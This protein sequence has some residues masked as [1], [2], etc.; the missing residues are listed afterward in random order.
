MAGAVACVLFTDLVGSTELMARVGDAAFDLLRNEHFGHLRQV[1]AR[2][3][4]SEIKNTGDGVLAAFPSAAEALGAAVAAQQ[5]TEAHA[6]RAE[7]NL[8]LRV[9]LALG[10]VAMEAGDVFGTPVVEA[11]RLVAAARPGQILC[12]ALTRAVAG[13]RAAVA[14]SEVGALELKGLPEPVPACE[15]M[16]EAAPA[17]ADV[18][19]PAL[20]AGTGRIFVG[21]DGDLA[22]LRQLWKESA[23]GERRTVMLGGEP[24]IGKTRLAT[25]LAQ[26]LHGEGALVLA[27]RCDEDLGVPYQPFVEALRHYMDHAPHPRLGR[28]AGELTRLVPEPPGPRPRTPGTVTCP[29]PRRSATACSMPSPVG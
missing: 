9:G 4:G 25:E 21:R 14:F 2:R 24:G 26:A 18:P 27:G 28:H 16:W 7:V 29:T 3:G 5:A 17:T 10:E 20:L 6:R 13:S 12:T 8:Q 22:R 23:A 15:V 19:L 11:A 1:I